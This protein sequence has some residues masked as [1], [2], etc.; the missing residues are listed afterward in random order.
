MVFALICLHA[1][2][3]IAIATGLAKII[4]NIVTID[5]G[6]LLVKFGSGI[7]IVTHNGSDCGF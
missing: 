6:K 1:G 2:P 4:N 3:S 5:F 7:Y